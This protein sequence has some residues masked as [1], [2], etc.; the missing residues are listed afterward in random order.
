M[1]ATRLS[2]LG[3]S[4]RRSILST[5]L[6]RRQTSQYSSQ[7]GSQYTQPTSIT[8]NQNSLNHTS[9]ISIDD[10]P[11]RDKNYQNLIISEI[12][13]FL[14]ANKFELE[15]NHPL[16]SKT[17]RQP[18]Q[19]DFIVIFQFL[20][21]KIDPYYKFLKSIETEI[22]VI[23]KN[24]DYPYLD[25]ITRSQISAV[26][27]TYW[28]NFLGILYWLV[29]LNLQV[30][31]INNIK[32]E[33]NLEDELD[34]IFINY[35]KKSYVAYINNEDGNFEKFY[36]ELEDEF[37]EF[38]NNLSAMITSKTEIKDNLNREFNELN[39]KYEHIRNVEKKSKALENDLIKFK[40]YIETMEDRKVKWYQILEKIT[41]EID[42]YDE[43]LMK[44]NE[45]RHELEVK[46]T[47]K[48]YNITIINNLNNERDSLSKSIDQTSHKLEEVKYQLKDKVTELTRSYESL[49]NFLKQYNTLVYKT[50]LE[51]D[52]EI[53]LNPNLMELNHGFKP[54]EI[55]SKSLKD[56]K[57]ELLNHRNE[58]NI[59]INTIKDQLSKLTES[60]DA[61][62]ETIIDQRETLEML[63]SQIL[64]N[65]S[66][67]DEIY[68]DMI[69]EQ[70]TYSMQIEK[71]ER[72]LRSIKI[73][74]NQEF[75]EIENTYQNTEIKLKNV[76]HEILKTKTVLHD[77]VQKILEFTIAFKVDIQQNLEDLEGFIVSEYEKFQT[78]SKPVTL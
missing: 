36:K 12:Y 26:G 13:E 1:G 67:Q 25:T 18:T 10:R 16:T 22:F 6:N 32:L 61:I 39:S 60:N 66:I 29:K 3:K 34:K 74:T 70:T 45:T 75:I 15:R 9:T 14:N 72:E 64:N 7:L 33:D 76:D 63:E 57:I 58:I 28:P 23:L 52:Y 35:T 31:D 5:P 48:G 4:D 46:L 71:L 21:N 54:H 59:A 65:K 41:K 77:N 56:A 38:N 55:L 37:N 2:I 49:D 40:A 78:I 44:L 69:N 24:L 73:N 51:G 42:K 27:G 43:E 68:E 19:K 50:Q 8:P 30:D 17:L 53:K 47:N 11:L 62:N 20:Y